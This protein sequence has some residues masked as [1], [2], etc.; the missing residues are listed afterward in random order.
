MDHVRFSRFFGDFFGDSFCDCL[1]DANITPHSSLSMFL[2]TDIT[3]PGIDFKLDLIQGAFLCK[4]YVL[5]EKSMWPDDLCCKDQKTTEEKEEM[6]TL[7]AI[8][9]K[10]RTDEQKDNLKLLR[11]IL[12]E[13]TPMCKKL[14]GDGIKDGI[15]K[16]GLTLRQDI[17]PCKYYQAPGDS[18]ETVAGCTMF[19]MAVGLLCSAYSLK[20]ATKPD[21]SDLLLCKIFGSLGFFGFLMGLFAIAL[22]SPGSRGDTAGLEGGFF[23]QVIGL[24]GVLGGV[25]TLLDAG[26]KDL[27][28]PALN[29]QS[30]DDGKKKTQVS[31]SV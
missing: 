6:A 1:V 11:D 8:E 14:N 4:D 7:E 16:D 2:S 28:M 3:E 18:A 19:A 22:F 24:C 21:P 12:P 10:E 30:F 31:P 25:I 15:S 26:N 29:F 5:D 27:V 17:K 13:C 9:P 20:A 23:L